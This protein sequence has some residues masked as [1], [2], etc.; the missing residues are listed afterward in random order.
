MVGCTATVRSKSALVAPMPIATAASWIISPASGAK[1]WQP[2]TRWVT[3]QTTSFIATRAVPPAKFSRIGVKWAVKTST[4]PEAAAASS[5]S[6]T[7]P[8][9]CGRV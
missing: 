5:V 8:S 1:M 9:S 6:P 2:S 7:V 4:G 3:A